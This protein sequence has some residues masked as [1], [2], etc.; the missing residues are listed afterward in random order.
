MKGSMLESLSGRNSS[1]LQLTLK[2]SSAT[3]YI[4]VVLITNMQN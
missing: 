3:L 1:P 4:L 2:G